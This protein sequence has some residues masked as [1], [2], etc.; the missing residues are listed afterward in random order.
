MKDNRP[1]S[2]LAEIG[3]LLILAE[4]ARQK[5]NLSSVSP[6]KMSTEEANQRQQQA[7]VQKDSSQR[8]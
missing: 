6:A 2:F 8:G 4:I 7:S 3:N 5:K 1:N